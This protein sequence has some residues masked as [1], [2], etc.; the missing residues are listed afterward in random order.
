MGPHS[1]TISTMGHEATYIQSL[2]SLRASDG[3]VAGG[4]GANL[5]ELIAAGFPVPDGFVL[6]T[7][8]YV[9]AARAASVDPADPEAA[10]DHL[11]N[12]KMPAAIAASAL[13]AYREL[14]AG[15]VAVRSSATAEDLPGAS[16]AGQQ[17]TYL[18]VRGKSALLDA[19]QRS[20]S[21][22]W[23]PRAL[24]Y[25]ARQGIDP[26][27]VSL[28]VVV[29]MMVPAE[30]SGILFTA[31]PRDFQKINEPPTLLY[32][33]HFAAG[34][35]PME[36]TDSIKTLLI[37]TAKALKGSA[38][39]LFMARTV[40][41]LGPGGQQLAARELGW[42]RMT[43]RKG[44]RELSSGVEC[45]DA[46]SLRGR[47]RAEDHLPNLLRDIQAL[48]DSQSQSDPQF[49]TNRLYTR[50]SAAEVRR[51]LIAQKGYSDTELPSAATIGAKLNALGYYPQTVAK[52][53]PQKKSPKR[54]RSLSN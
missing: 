17:D 8:A 44:M 39:R 21:S 14:G 48:V 30:V 29:Q 38:R 40:K 6:T 10:A 7:E 43:I 16:F 49:R 20:W 37:T 9:V 18:N 47:K 11:R 45:I 1:P 4:K 15:P 46:F 34:G 35:K 3:A 33:R 52:S 42:G 2:A 23:T 28:A 19:V 31:N 25:C 53:R 51:Q 22:L 26:S 13:E 32:S 36:L 24:N 12:G 27:T 50:L 41:E 54:M 5:G